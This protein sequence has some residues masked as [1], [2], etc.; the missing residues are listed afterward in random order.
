MVSVFVAIVLISG[1]TGTFAI[2][3][4]NNTVKNLIESS[5]DGVT[6]IYNGAVV[7]I[8]VLLAHKIGGHFVH[9]F[10]VGD[11]LKDAMKQ[12]ERPPFDKNGM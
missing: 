3:V 11:A 2:F 6:T 8:G 1:L 10:S 4:I 5:A 9:Q 7:L 12:M